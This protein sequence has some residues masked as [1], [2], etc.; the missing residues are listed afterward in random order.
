[1]SEGLTWQEGDI[2]QRPNLQSRWEFTGFVQQENP[3]KFSLSTC[4]YLR[5]VWCWCYHCVSPRVFLDYRIPDYQVFIDIKIGS[6]QPAE[7]NHRLFLSQKKIKARFSPK[8]IE[9]I[10]KRRR[11]LGPVVVNSII[12]HQKS[13]EGNDKWYNF[14]KIR[15]HKDFWLLFMPLG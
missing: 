11:E 6:T 5:Y 4:L 9:A 2:R 13:I 8:K 7:S 14:T 15:C 12:S 3:R 10:S 1:M